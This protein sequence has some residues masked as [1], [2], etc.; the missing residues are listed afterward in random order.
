M[1]TLK[2]QIV[3]TKR[4]SLILNKFIE[5]T[6]PDAYKVSADKNNTVLT[7]VATKLLHTANLYF[8]NR[9]IL[10]QKLQQRGIDGMFF[11]NLPVPHHK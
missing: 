6:I 5:T 10:A 7:T 2:N 4:K 11:K 3:E 1:P 8:Y 9:G